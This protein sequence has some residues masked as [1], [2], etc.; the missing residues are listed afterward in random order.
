MGSRKGFTKLSIL[1]VFAIILFGG[2]LIATHEP[3][4]P[5]FRLSQENAERD[6]ALD[7]ERTTVVARIE[8]T[9][10][11]RPI[12]H[13]EPVSAVSEPPSKKEVPQY[14]PQ[15]GCTS[16]VNPRFTH[17]FS[18][19]STID[20]LNPIGGIGGGSPG[21]SYIGVKEGMEAPVY[22]PL[23]AILQTIIYVDRGAGYGE[24][25]LLFRVSCEVT[26]LFDHIDRLSDKLKPYAPAT[27][28]ASSKTQDGKELNLQIKA[29]E[30]LGYS[31]GTELARTFDFLVIN[32]AKKN[33]YINP[34]RW[35]WDQA[36][37]GTCP[38]DYFT[39][40]LK[41][42]YYAKLGKPSDTGFI[43]ADSCGNPSHDVAGTASGG[44]FKGDSTD[45]RGEYLA[46][47]H[48]YNDARISYRKDGMAFPSVQDVQQGNPYLNI[49]DF[50][51]QQFPEDITPGE[52]VCYE[53][54]GMWG[55]IRLD[56]EMQLSLAKGSGACPS[57]FPD[58][59]A[60]TWIR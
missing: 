7:N 18:D 27:P 11:T 49:T 19:L 2:V 4:N 53:G 23:D 15:S 56:S 14:A 3:G 51:P 41:A 58:S 13:A 21:R 46:I 16:N 25:G 50:S 31:N 42:Q 17:S 34:K 8:T 39:P 36:L 38:Y 26:I 35:E 6:V 54:N 9:E 44:W 1:G 5:P 43:K 60:D 59:Q 37:Y 29:G 22:A 32:Y 55:Y 40:D 52:S 28:A 47:A 33:A 12:T 20:A 45:S 48:E 30:L 57:A 24:Y 10:E